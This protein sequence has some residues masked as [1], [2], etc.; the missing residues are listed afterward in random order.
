MDLNERQISDIAGAIKQLIGAGVD[1]LATNIIIKTADKK[2][3]SE[4]QG[5]IKEESNEKTSE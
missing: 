5:K 1:I 2:S 4:D 3:N